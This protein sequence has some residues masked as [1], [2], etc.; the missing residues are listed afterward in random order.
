[1]TDIN[2]IIEMIEKVRPAIIGN[3]YLDGYDDACDDIIEQLRKMSDWKEITCYEDMPEDGR[4]W[5]FFDANKDYHV[6]SSQDAR[7]HFVCGCDEDGFDVLSDEPYYIE[8]KL[9]HFMKLK[10][11]KPPNSKEL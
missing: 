7:C 8:F 11:P 5:L 1:M 10:A 9:T 6:L 3:D 2:S 4:E